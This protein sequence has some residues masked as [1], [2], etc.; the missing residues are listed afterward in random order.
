[1]TDGQS[2][3]LVLTL[4]Y[5]IECV[6]FAPLG[7]LALVSRTGGFGHCSPRSALMMAWGMK[8][9]VFI[10]PL[11][12][13]PGTL[14]FV[15]NQNE[16]RPGNWKISTVS[17]I[18]RHQSLIRNASKTLRLLAVLNFLNFFAVLPLL[19]V[20]TYDE[21]T[22]LWG[23]AYSYAVLFATA[24]HYH[25]LH[26]R[27][28]P[29]F[30]ADRLKTTLYTA[31][32]PWHAPRCYDELCQ[33]SS[34]RWDPIAAWI[35][36]AQNKATLAK[37]QQYWRDAH[38]L[39]QPTYPARA[40]EDALKQSELNYSNWLDA[41][42]NP[43]GSLYCPCCHAGFEKPAEQCSDCDGVALKSSALIVE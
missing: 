15:S 16:K 2:F 40:L 37:L 6:T 31:L 25:A 29:S 32:L 26:K 11:L 35:A 13:W 30:A 3:Y 18:R 42:K 9:S 22:I 5:L 36:N 7:S 33:K 24:A 10:A 1:M 27:L 23:L 19:Y 14:Y 12:P 28:L 38:F 21:A 43:E 39:K 34:L 20:R 4:F 17:G 8:K 41:P